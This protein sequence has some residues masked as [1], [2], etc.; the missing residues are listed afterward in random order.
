MKNKETILFVAPKMNNFILNDLKIL[1]KEYIIIKNFYNYNKKYFTPFYIAHQFIFLLFKINSIDKI[2]IQFAGYW[3]ILPTL[4]SKFFN[5]K[6]IIISHGTDC[7]SIPSL[8]YGNLRKRIL[9]KICLVSYNS[10]D[11]ICPVS[12][13]L[14]KVE[15]KFYNKKQEYNQGIL[16]F[17]PNLKT[18]FN[19]IHNGL[20]IDF[21]YIEK[22]NKKSNSFLAV[23]SKKQYYLKGGDLI[24]NIAK[25]FNHCTFEIVGL[26]KP[27]HIKKLPNNLKFEG[28]INMQELREKYNKSEYFFQL[29]SFEGFGLSLCEAML[30]LC[31]PI[32]SSVNMI[33]E[34]IGENGY[35]LQQK[36]EQK[37]IKIIE[38]VLNIKNKKLMAEKARNSI[39]LRYNLKTREVNLLKTISKL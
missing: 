7:A 8:N 35:I 34:I 14:I 21:W 25:R 31:I 5:K 36:N 28:H 30:G 32:G 18:D 2:I 11:L 29:S 27:K 15:N 13:S 38:R 16:S 6:S 37:L 26:H 12:N 4:F 39:K 33:P 19:V 9:N 10:C 22:Y 1:S 23:F 3:S 24:L 20:D 17:Y